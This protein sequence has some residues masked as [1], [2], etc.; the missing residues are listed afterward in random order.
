MPTTAE[1][2]SADLRWLRLCR[3]VAMPVQRLYSLEPSGRVA[4]HTWY[5]PTL[6]SC[7]GVVWRGHSSRSSTTTVDADRRSTALHGRYM[8][9]NAWRAMLCPS[10]VRAATS[11]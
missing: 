11:L 7:A 6:P 3:S 2:A 1:P 8:T 10:D 5:D 4:L 9:W